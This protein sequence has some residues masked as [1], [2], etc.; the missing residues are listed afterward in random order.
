MGN[1]INK[2][3]N[4]AQKAHAGQYRKGTDVPYITH[5]LEAGT[6]AASLTDDENVIAAAILHDTI[7]DTA[8]SKDDIFD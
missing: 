1:I 8:V 3:V 5:V 7:E 2:A 4:F 6:I